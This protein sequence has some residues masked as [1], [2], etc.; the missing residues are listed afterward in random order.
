MRPDKHF[1][2]RTLGRLSLDAAVGDFAAPAEIRPRHLAILTVLALSRRP[3]RR[4][5]LAD[6]FW[7][8]QEDERARH[9]LSNALSALRGVLGS[10]AITARRDE[11]A[12]SEDVR[13]AVDAIEFDA[14]VEAHDDERAVA[15]Y[16]GEFLEDVVVPDA[17]GFDAWV[18]RERARLQRGFLAA[19]ERRA[20][21]LLRARDWG[22]CAGLADRWLRAAPESTLAL[23]TLLRARS[24]PGTPEALRA[25]LA[26]FERARR[27]LTEEHGLKPD[28]P[29][30]SIV[31]E[32][33]AQLAMQE[34]A[35]ATSV[36]APAEHPQA[37]LPPRDS[38]VVVASSARVAPA[39]KASRR[40]RR[41][42]FGG[43]AL[44]AAIML[45]ATALF[46][47]TGTAQPTH[48]VIAIPDIQDVR[49]DTA[50]RW[51]Q[52]GLPQLITNDLAAGG[53]IVDAVAP[54]RVRDVIL[55]RGGAPDQPLPE[56]EALD[57]ARRV[58]ATW[59]VT[60]GLTG[61][62]GTYILDLEVRDVASGD[63]VESFTVMA[64][65]PVQLGHLAAARLLD[66]ASVNAGHAGDP[67]RFASASTV[68]PEAYRHYV[69]GLDAE[70][71][72]RL[73]DVTREFDA[74][75][76]LDSGFV[77]AIVE[78]RTIALDRGDNAL[79]ARLDSLIA[80]H[81]ERLSDWE[82]LS[83]EV[84]RATNEGAIGRSEALARHL[85][86]RFPRDPRAYTVLAGVLVTHGHWLAADSVL[87]R[88]LS[89]DSLAIAA[90]DGPCAPCAAYAGLVDVRLSRGDL[91]SAERAARRWVALQPGIPGAWEM[92]SM[93]LQ[94]AGR[95]DEAIEAARRAASLGADPVHVG[96]LGRVL[97]VTRHF[98]T[99]DS[100]IRV[101]RARGGS[102]ATEALDLQDIAA[103]ERGQFGVAARLLGASGD[104][105][106]LLLVQADNLVRLGRLAEARRLYERSG[107]PT[108][109]PVDALDAEQARGFT[110]AHVLEGDAM[111]RAGDV[112]P[113]AAL[114]DSVRRVGAHSYYGRD[115]GLYHHLTGLLALAH[116]D[117]AEAERELEKARWG[118][119]GWTRT[120]ETIARLHL[121]TGD[122]GG[123]ITALRDAR[124][125][126]LDAM[127]R[128][129]PRTEL[130][131]WLARA[132][133]AAGRPDSA[134]VYA[135]R[136]RAAWA[137]ADPEVRRL[138]P[139]LPR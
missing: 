88:E 19:C 27:W 15:V 89:L 123:A 39:A 78:R 68:S 76:A 80:H 31:A 94:Y 106:G 139:G 103:R 127:G 132:F 137:D 24:G 34:R 70:S 72:R 74:A 52:D 77:D 113:L 104:T 73:A 98:D 6:L 21:T 90:G 26:D 95:D 97:L 66:I 44:A 53:G 8:E 5:A 129:V 105:S 55:R 130:D 126:P 64:P 85:V 115:W 93:A 12:L 38:G 102:A 54:V 42:A 13:L 112:A 46:R 29:A 28:A 131:Y 84:T 50:L 3:L 56:T 117:T 4:D 71:E 45:T 11:V 124:E 83:D 32:L 7:G 1:R 133:A 41:G 111:W 114:V 65:D 75:I 10:G 91:A 22:A 125:G 60:G 101:L 17:P 82:R 51:L 110:W 47:R 58:G 118:I 20:P 134:H 43:V 40:W 59:S 57:V 37:G 81:P 109:V 2:L 36:A 35:L 33:Q 62:S 135:D 119:S 100:V 87:L 48:T 128:Y 61:A 49:G 116:G 30:Q 121:A 138:L 9:S 63:P 86:A 122:A 108:R 107:H 23:T 67:P 92:L 136:V 14:A 18:V 69:L 16:T 25:A 120:L 99:A 96:N 79:A